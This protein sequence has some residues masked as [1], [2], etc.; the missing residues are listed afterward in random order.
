MTFRAPQKFQLN[1]FHKQDKRVRICYSDFSRY[2][3]IAS[4]ATGPSPSPA[5]LS[6]A[7]GSPPGALYFWGQIV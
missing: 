6:E 2:Y 4:P 1:I 5:P 7:P 3:T